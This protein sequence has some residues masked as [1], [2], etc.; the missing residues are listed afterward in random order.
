MN[1][2]FTSDVFRRLSNDPLTAEI[3]AEHVAEL[4]ANLKFQTFR[5]DGATLAMQELQAELQRTDTIVNNAA[6]EAKKWRDH[7]EIQNAE[8]DRLN[9]RCDEL[10][11][12]AELGKLAME[13]I[14]KVELEKQVEGLQSQVTLYR[15]VLERARIAFINLIDLKLLPSPEYEK[16]ANN[17]AGDIFMVLSDIPAEA[18]EATEQLQALIGQAIDIWNQSKSVRDRS[19]YEPLRKNL[20]QTMDALTKYRGE[21]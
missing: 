2:K 5:A 9:K 14:D 6:A 19:E 15:P 16:V 17:I 4:V 13:A 1:D 21:A 3:M 18:T 7:A 12:W 10:K 8:I 11:P 20:D